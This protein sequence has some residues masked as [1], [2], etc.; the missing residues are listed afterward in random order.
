MVDTNF[1]A[2][3]VFPTAGNYRVALRVIPK[4][5]PQ[6]SDSSVMVIKV[7]A[8]PKGISYFPINAMTG[9]P[10][11]LVARAIGDV[12]QWRPSTGIEQRFHQVAYFESNH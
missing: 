10:I 6:L 1:N 11:S 7:E 2:S 9:K 5:C 12:Y 8:P 4:D 3:H